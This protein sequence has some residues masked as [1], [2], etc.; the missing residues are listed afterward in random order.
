MTWTGKFGSL[1]WLARGRLT[2]QIILERGLDMGSWVQSGSIRHPSWQLRKQII[3]S[4]CCVLDMFLCT[5]SCLQELFK[6]VCCFCQSCCSITNCY[7]LRW[8]IT[9]YC[10]RDHRKS[11]INWNVEKVTL[12][13]LSPAPPNPTFAL[14]NSETAT[15]ICC[16]YHL[17]QMIC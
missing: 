14:P 7:I 10:W 13:S 2:V 6:V 11:R 12:E 4:S 15:N 3:Q 8:T 9:S 1:P 17:D 16:C 5:P